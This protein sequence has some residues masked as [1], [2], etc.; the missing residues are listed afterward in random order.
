MP[1]YADPLSERDVCLNCMLTD[2]NSAE[3][4]VR[5]QFPFEAGT[6]ENADSLLRLIVLSFKL[7][8]LKLGA[9]KRESRIVLRSRRIFCKRFLRDCEMPKQESPIHGILIR[10]IESVVNRY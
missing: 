4:K 7:F 1:R 8:V 6:L 10:T 2:E 5:Q 9:G 3:N